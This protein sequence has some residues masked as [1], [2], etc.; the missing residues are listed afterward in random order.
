MAGTSCRQYI[1]PYAYN[2]Q[3]KTDYPYSPPKKL[4]VKCAIEVAG[5]GLLMSPLFRAVVLKHE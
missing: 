4:L 3:T 2:D 1:H 5:V